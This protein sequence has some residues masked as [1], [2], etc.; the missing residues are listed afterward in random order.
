MRK[1]HRCDI[2]CM[3]FWAKEWLSGSKSLS[4]PESDFDSSTLAAIQYH[5][6][7]LQHSDK[8][9]S[10][11]TLRPF[12]TD[13]VSFYST[14][15]TLD[16]RVAF[17]S[18]HPPG[19]PTY[20]SRYDETQIPSTQSDFSFQSFSICVRCLD[21]GTLIWHSFPLEIST[22]ELWDSS[23]RCKWECSWGMM[24]CPLDR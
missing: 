1:Y 12:Q 17:L 16:C 14:D 21:G 10:I 19:H 15:P 24:E 9:F 20:T 4:E 13:K 18:P 22:W 11:W 23:G 8:P 7:S 3:S 5:Q 6:Y 2:F